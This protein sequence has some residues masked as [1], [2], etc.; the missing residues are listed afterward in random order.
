VPRCP[1]D[2][3]DRE[4]H[5]RPLLL[6][7]ELPV[8]RP[9]ITVADHL[10]VASTQPRAQLRVALEGHGARAEADRYRVLVEHPVQPP[11]ADAAPELEMRLRAEIAPGRIDRRRVLTPRVV[12]AVAVQQVQL[13]AL[14]VVDDE[15]H[16][17]RG[18]VRPAELGRPRAIAHEVARR[19]FALR[20]P[21]H[22]PTLLAPLR[23]SGF[24]RR[25]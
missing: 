2:Q 15:A 4:P 16:R 14:L 9:A 3:C 21:G 25:P 24:G 17:D 22:R 11:D 5:P 7:L 8:V 23:A 13:G 6:A 20:R 18:P 12:D 10:V 19:S 1:L